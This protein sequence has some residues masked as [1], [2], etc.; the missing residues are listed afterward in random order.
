MWGTEHVPITVMVGTINNNDVR[1]NIYYRFRALLLL[2]LTLDKRIS[3]KHLGS[4]YIIPYR[5]RI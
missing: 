5:D 1:I 3:I 2:I 4:T